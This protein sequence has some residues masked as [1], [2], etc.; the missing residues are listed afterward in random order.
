MTS[1]NY[2]RRQWKVAS[3]HLLCMFSLSANCVVWALVA[4]LYATPLACIALAVAGTF[5]GFVA[6]VKWHDAE[7]AWK[8][9][10]RAQLGMEVEK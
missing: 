2:Y 1:Y 5:F 10:L 7:I 3:A 6:A 8:R 4:G 9:C